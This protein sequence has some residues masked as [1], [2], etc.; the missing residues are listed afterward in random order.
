MFGLSKADKRRRAEHEADLAAWR[1]LCD[2]EPVEDMLHL[3][4]EP[5]VRI[6]KYADG[7]VEHIRID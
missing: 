5:P 4:R 7:R 6:V 1:A 3:D 2:A